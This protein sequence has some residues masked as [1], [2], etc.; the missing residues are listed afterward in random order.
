MEERALWWNMLGWWGKVTEKK[1]LL[2]EC[3][4][5]RKIRRVFNQEEFTNARYKGFSKKGLFGRLYVRTWYPEISTIPMPQE[6]HWSQWVYEV[7][8]KGLLPPTLCSTGGD[9]GD[10]RSSVLGESSHPWD[11]GSELWLHEIWTAFALNNSIF[12]VISS[13]T[14]NCTV[15]SG[16]PGNNMQFFDCPL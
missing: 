6:Y 5:I 13:K 15:S 9:Y 7:K 16:K 10:G 2:E 1:T 8:E 3:R 11:W 4:W 12:T 14:N